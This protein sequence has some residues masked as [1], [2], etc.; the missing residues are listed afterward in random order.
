[1]PK[2]KQLVR[3]RSRIWT[4]STGSPSPRQPRCRAGGREASRPPAEPAS[5]RKAV[6]CSCGSLCGPR[7]AGTEWRRRRPPG[8]YCPN[9]CN[10]NQ[11]AARAAKGWEWA[12]DLWGRG[13]LCCH[14]MTRHVTPTVKPEAR[15]LCTVPPCSPRASTAAQHFR[16]ADPGP[17]GSGPAAAG[18]L[19]HARRPLCSAGV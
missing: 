11:G 7:Q 13:P 1:M 17:L 12:G 10:R 8:G 2:Q 19:L 14:V 16:G 15:G 3:G 5:G 9:R 4:G 18:S 6:Y